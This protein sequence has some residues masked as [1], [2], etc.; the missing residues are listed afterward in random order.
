LVH[1]PPSAGTTSHKYLSD[2]RG[3]VLFIMAVMSVVLAIFFVGLAEIGRFLIL[4]EQ[5]Y[6]AADAAAL[7][8]SLSGVQKMVKIRVITDRGEEEHCSCDENSCDCWCSSCGTVVREVTGREVDLIDNGGWRDYCVPFCS[9]GRGSCDYEIL[10]RWV[11]YNPYWSQRAAESFFQANRPWLADLAQVTRI[12]IHGDRRDPFYPSV[13]VYAKAIIQSIAPKLFS[14][15]P[16][17]YTTDVCAQGDTFYRD[18][19]T[20]KWSPAPPDA[21]WND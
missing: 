3:A 21:C 20:K 14:V 16:E 6:T 8:A 18:P 7:A 10:E 9:C 2:E 5:T 1:M 4:R 19:H 15:F 11:Q 17:S 12:N 13:T